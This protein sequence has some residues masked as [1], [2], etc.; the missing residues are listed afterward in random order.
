MI[1]SNYVSQDVFCAKYYVWSPSL[2]MKILDRRGNDWE[3]PD[4]HLIQSA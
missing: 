1:S 2:K 3:E 4:F